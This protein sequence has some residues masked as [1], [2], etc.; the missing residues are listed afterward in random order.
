MSQ[1]SGLGANA[2][3]RNE[4]LFLGRP[5]YL[6]KSFVLHCHETAAHIAPVQTFCRK[7]RFDSCFAE[8]EKLDDERR[9]R[10]VGIDVKEQH[11]VLSRKRQETE[12]GRPQ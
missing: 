12:A 3:V 9:G 7:Q 5:G 4:D 2:A 6:Y 10:S 8:R 1:S 11:K